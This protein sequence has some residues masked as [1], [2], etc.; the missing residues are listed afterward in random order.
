[1]NPSMHL[2]G[3]ILL[4][5]IF[6]ISGVGKLAD[7]AGTAGFMES[8]GVPGILVW[9]TLA[10]EILG[11][12]ALVIGFQTRIAAFALAVFSIAAAVIF[13][14]NFADQMQMI[15]FLKN[16][17]IAGGLLLLSASGALALGVDCRK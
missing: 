8:M 5:L 15:L 16:L 11:G 2:I 3:R 7:P 12:I 4:A 13:H 17:S 6:I 9:P 14:H 1:M 10:L